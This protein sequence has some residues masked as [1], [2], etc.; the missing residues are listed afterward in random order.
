[1]GTID[2]GAAFGFF[3]KDRGWFR[4]FLIA[5][6]LTY[7]LVGSIPVL[8]WSVE[9]A[10]R[11]LNREDEQLP[12]WDPFWGTWKTG[13][14][15]WLVNLVWLLPVLLSVL[16]LYLPVIFAR[17]LP[18]EQLLVIIFAAL[19][20]V[21]TFITVYTALVFF[22]EP[23]VLGILAEGGSLGTAVNPLNAWK[24]ARRHLGPHLIVF[25]IVGLGLTTVIS[26]LAPLTLFLLL[27]PMLVYA[28]MV[29]AHYA[30]QLARLEDAA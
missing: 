12:G 9:I 21:L 7:T 11:A 5:S 30:G 23:A 28:G 24:R 14:K 8:G 22:L 17:S 26:V 15:F 20:C 29:L 6:L 2:Y 16:V 3:L 4:K 27:P 25:A 1:M 19:L 13:Y 10:R 18:G